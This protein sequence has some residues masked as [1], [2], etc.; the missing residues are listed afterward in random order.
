[1]SPLGNAELKTLPWPMAETRNEQE[2]STDRTVTS[3]APQQLSRWACL[4]ISCSL[5]LLAGT[6]A[7]HIP[8]GLPDLVLPDKEPG[9]APD[10]PVPAGTAEA[11]LKSSCALHTAV[12]MRC[13]APVD[14]LSHIHG[15]TWAGWQQLWLSQ[16]PMEA[17]WAHAAQAVSVEWL[18]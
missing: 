17:A 12:D 4:L 11:R 13:K 14:M 15:W 1:M 18:L 6:G 7:Q 8:P 2:M 5:K 9:V 10:A 3:L 16:G